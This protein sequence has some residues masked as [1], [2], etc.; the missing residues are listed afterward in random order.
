MHP[1][2]FTIFGLQIKWYGILI[3]L[4]ILAGVAFAWNRAKKY[5]LTKDNLL[6][7]AF[8]IIIVGII[9]ARLTYIIAN[10]GYFAQNPAEI[11]SIQMEG[12]SFIGIIL[13]NIPAVWIFAR[14]KKLSFWRITDLAAPSIAIGYFFGR[15][16]CTVNGCCY[17]PQTTSVCNIAGRF[18]TQILNALVAV[19]IFLA[20]WWLSKE[21]KLKQGE[22]FI[23][24][25]YLY[26]ITHIG[27]EFLR[28]DA[29]HSPIMGTPLNIAQWLN[30][31][32]ILGGYAVHF[33]LR[34]GTEPSMVDEARVAEIEEIDRNRGKKSISIEGHD[35]SDLPE[36][37]SAEDSVEDTND[38][39]EE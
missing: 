14:I 39:T 27:T 15:L 35:E 25:I 1:T 30:I 4:G 13:F 8:V 24:F 21:K 29:G 3:T 9:G 31:L 12:L 18:P 16:G 5:G 11:L 10:F 34:K 33:F 19:V 2:A 32:L 22:L 37:E 7:L 6:D 28:A 20:L 38:D 26:A 17:G 23:Y 36:N